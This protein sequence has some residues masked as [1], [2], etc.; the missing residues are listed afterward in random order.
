M[1]KRIGII[2]NFSPETWLGGINYY[3]NLNN[4]LD[5][6]K[7]ELR[8]FCGSNEKKFCIKNFK[9]SKVIV[10]EKFKYP[11][12]YL[13][14]LSK[15]KILFFG[16]DNSLIYF[17]KENKIDV[18][19]GYYLGRYSQVDSIPI[20]WDFQELHNPENFSL[21]EIILRK[22]NNFM[23]ASNSNKVLLS[24]KPDQLIFNKIYNKKKKSNSVYINMPQ[25]LNN[26]KLINKTKILRKF[27][28]NNNYFILPNH[29]WK[30]KNHILVLK[31]LKNIKKKE[32]KNIQIVSTGNNKDWRHK[33]NFQI[34]N[35]YVKE[36]N[37]RSNYK[38]LGI[39]SENHILNLIYHSIALINP[40][41]SEGESGSVEM[42]KVFQKLTLLSN[43]DVHKRQKIKGSFFFG[44]NDFKKLG[45]YLLMLKKK[46]KFKSEISLKKCLKIH[47]KYIQEQKTKFTNLFLN[48][49]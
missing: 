25:N 2:I 39:V 20:I 11:K 26:F 17:L 44:V 15:I 13:G 6:K 10:T 22:F 33:D 8:I 4:L 21:K 30:H 40:S 29:Y 35:K 3:I 24:T 36:N 32:L 48:T 42:A 18:L 31:A 14:P 12:K 47:T 5:K 19:F 23:C 16:K 34:I 37:L 49:N 1:K 46:Y 38:I 41:K 9:D 27:K 45:I 43:L 7:F 28:I